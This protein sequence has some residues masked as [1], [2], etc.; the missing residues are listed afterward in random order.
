MYFFEYPW[1]HPHACGDKQYHPLQTTLFLGSSPRVWGQERIS[2]MCLL[3]QGIIPTR[4][5]TSSAILFMSADKKDH[6]H[7]CGDKFPAKEVI[8]PAG[9]SSP[10]VW[11][12]DGF[13]EAFRLIA[14]I[15]PTRV[16]TRRR[17]R[18]VRGN[19]EDHPHACGDKSHAI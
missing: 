1:D 14:G 12:Q 2:L 9:G 19:Q 3:M 7:A 10:R 8:A 15:I 18:Q 13:V 16:G 11:G 4:V 5:G 6:P 17:N